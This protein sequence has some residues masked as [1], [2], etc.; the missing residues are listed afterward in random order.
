MEILKKKEHEFFMQTPQG[1][2]KATV[3]HDQMKQCL[4]GSTLFEKRF[5]VAWHKTGQLGQP[6][7]CFQVEVFVCPTCGE[8]IG[9]DSKTIA[10][11]AAEQ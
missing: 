6:P 3:Q 5:L 10:E 11:R 8:E 7:M 2:V 4:C 9:P 1:V